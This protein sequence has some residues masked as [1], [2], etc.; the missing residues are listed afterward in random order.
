MTAATA[1]KPDPVQDKVPDKLA[2]DQCPICLTPDGNPKVYV[3]GIAITPNRRV[4]LCPSCS[5]EWERL[6]EHTIKVK[7]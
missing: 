2:V 1:K 6:I 5:H 3:S 4:W 7:S